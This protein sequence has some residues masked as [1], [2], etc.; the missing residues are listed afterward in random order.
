MTCRNLIFM[1]PGAA[2]L[3]ASPARRTFDVR[4]HG[5]AGDGKTLSTKVINTAI[6]DAAGG[7]VACLPPGDY[8]SG[9]VAI[10][11]NVTPYLEAGATLLGSKNLADYSMQSG[12][13]AKGDANQKHLVYARDA[14][15]AGLAGPGRIDGQGAAFRI[16]NRRVVRAPDAPGDCLRRR[17]AVRCRRTASERIGERSRGS[18]TDRHSRCVLAK[19]RVPAR[20]KVFLD[21]QGSR[22]ARIVLAVSD[23]SA[24]EKAVQLGTVVPSTA[25]E[26]K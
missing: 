11:S 20:T 15:N 17:E 23:L 7:G 19:C 18:E 22:S 12:P 4:A 26:V 6:D 25:I 21:V 16:P 3:A 24:A 1:S 8:L 14:E 13:P 10:K 9:T 5:A 2:A